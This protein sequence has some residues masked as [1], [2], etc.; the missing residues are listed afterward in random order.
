M[1]GFNPAWFIALGVTLV[2]AG[3]SFMP[4]DIRAKIGL[5][6]VG[7]GFIMILIG[8]A[9]ILTMS[10]QPDR[11]REESGQFVAVPSSGPPA[12]TRKHHGPAASVTLYR[13]T[14]VKF[15]HGLNTRAPLITCRDPNGMP[16]YPGSALMPLDENT[17]ML[18]MVTP[19]TGSCSAVSP[20]PWYDSRIMKTVAA[21]AAFAWRVAILALLAII[22]FEIRTANREL[23]TI[24]Q[25]MPEDSQVN[26]LEEKLD[27]LHND[28]ESLWTLVNEKW[29]IAL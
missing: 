29:R 26:V 27:T 28:A 22:A 6:C 9:A 24:A 7:S 10:A 14:L 20:Q 21:Y 11:R 3:Y 1:F 13:E 25:Q 5:T 15:K 19:Q 12:A 4:P 23:R 2:L 17:V 8:I 18:N 16:M